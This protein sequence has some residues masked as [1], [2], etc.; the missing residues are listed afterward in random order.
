MGVF[1]LP[2][3]FFLS[4][5]RIL[6]TAF[7]QIPADVREDETSENNMSTKKYDLI[8]LRN[9]LIYGLRKILLKPKGKYSKHDIVPLHW[10][11]NI[12]SVNVFV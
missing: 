12:L 1:L 6:R 10:K 2:L 5:L 9:P 8:L 4:Q 11:R 7:A 3:A